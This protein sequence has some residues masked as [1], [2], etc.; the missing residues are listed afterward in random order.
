GGRLVSVVT[1]AELMRS[2]NL[3]AGATRSP[4]VFYTLA[5]ALYLVMTSVSTI[6][7]QRAEARA[8]RGIRRA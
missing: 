8:N 7:F 1:L 5:A 6:L 2:A 3:A 4:F